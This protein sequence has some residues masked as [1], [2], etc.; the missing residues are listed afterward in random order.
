MA[1]TVRPAPQRPPAAVVHALPFAGDDEALVEGLRA[2]SPVAVAALC[3][4]YGAHVLSVLARILGA[5]DTELPDLHHDALLRA[6]RSAKQI[7]DPAALRGWLSIIAVNVART[8]IHRRSRRR[9]LRFLPWSEL[10]EVEAP[11]AAEEDVEALRGTYAILAELPADERIAFA[12]RFIDGMEL[13]EV[14]AASGVSLATI[15]RRLRR[16]EQRF[17]SRA[18]REPALAAWVEGGARWGRR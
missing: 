2:E 8:A 6:V 17:V 14:A 9:W 15:K 7:E 12:L 16:A 3:D 4:R 1:A 5:D 13:T 10:P 11:A 18:R